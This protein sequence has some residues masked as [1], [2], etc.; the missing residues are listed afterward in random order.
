MAQ[1]YARI[2]CSHCEE[3]II[4]CRQCGYEFEEGDTV[5]CTSEGHFCSWECFQEYMAEKYDATETIT[6]AEEPEDELEDEY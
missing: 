5:I 6:Y 3:E 1:T 2:F 4:S